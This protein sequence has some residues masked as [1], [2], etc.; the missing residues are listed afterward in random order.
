MCIKHS[1]F[2]L[3]IPEYALYA[4]LALCTQNL[5]VLG[6]AKLLRQIRILIP[7]VG[8][9]RLLPFFRTVTFPSIIPECSLLGELSLTGC[10][11]ISYYIPKV[12]C[13]YKRSV[14]RSAAKSA[15]ENG[16]G[17]Q[18][19][20]SGTVTIADAHTGDADLRCPDDII[21]SV[22]NHYAAVEFCAV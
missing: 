7:Y 5:A 10:I 12:Y 3:R 13:Y 11:L 20:C 16:V 19:F 22:S 18:Q 15:T 1:A 9:H 4:L 14:R 8:L 17:N 2:F 21:F 6:R